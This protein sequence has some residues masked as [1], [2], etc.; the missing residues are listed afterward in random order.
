MKTLLKTVGLCSVAGR[1]M[2]A[3]VSVQTMFTWTCSRISRSV[4]EDLYACLQK[5][6][7]GVNMYDPSS[8]RDG[9]VTQ[10]LHT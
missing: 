8:L 1:V 7:W 9:Y 10:K 5:H 4:C 6:Q 3:A 2:C